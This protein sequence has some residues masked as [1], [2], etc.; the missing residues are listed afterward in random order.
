MT[1]HSTTA[2]EEL[3]RPDPKRWRVLA[4]LSVAQFM[5]I[6]DVTVV[7]IALPSIGVDLGLSRATLTWVVTAYTLMF[8]GLMLLGGRAADIFGARRLVLTGLTIFT[9][10]SLVA[11]LSVNAEMLIGG[12]I[13]QGIGAALLSPAALSIVTTT[14]HGTERNKALGV[15]GALGGTG[16]AVGVLFGGLITAGPGWEWI[17]YINVPIGLAV[18]AA[19]PSVVHTHRTD[20]APR[21]IDL[22]GA[23]TVTLATAAAIYGLINAGDYGW[24]ATS[25]LVPLV[26]AAALYGSFVV[27]ERAVRSPLVN[28]QILARRRVVAGAFLMLVATGLL[29]ASF[30][31]G[32]FYLQHLRGYSALTTGLL[33]LP[34]A[35]GTIIGAHS[36]SRAVGRIGPRHV[37]GSALAIAA[38]GAGVPAI[39]STPATVVLGISIAAAGLGA[40]FVAATTTALSDVQHH[41]AGVTSGVINTFHEIGG[42]V[43]VAAISTI[44]AASLTAQ[45][46]VATTGF[47]NAFAFSAITA[48]VAALAALVVVPAGRISVSAHVGMH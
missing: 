5:L 32:S 44:A 4:L 41:E 27:I 1:T 24:A 33:F 2:A 13:G 43:G 28:L 21:R 30:F 42:A 15:W 47:T 19:L 11:G 31:V 22:P 17:F 10:S 40:T 14:F 23:A 7:T 34:V 6:L 35:V 46:T 18:L 3:I 37:A 26:L 29:I 45:G 39:W 36:A 38:I 9:A 12:R 16:A 48:A 8:G 20:R 25:T